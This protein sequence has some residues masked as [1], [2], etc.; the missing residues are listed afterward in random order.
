MDTRALA[1]LIIKEIKKIDVL[2]LPM[3]GGDEMVKAKSEFYRIYEQAYAKAF[4]LAVPAQTKFRFIKRVIGK[5]IRPYTRQQTEFNYQIVE[6]VKAQQNII[7]KHQEIL[8]DFFLAD[9]ELN[10]KMERTS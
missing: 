1:D 3:F 9:H 4:T 6:L 5:L 10:K 8:E 7:V 2:S